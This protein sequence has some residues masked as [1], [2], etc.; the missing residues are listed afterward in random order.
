MVAVQ[1]WLWWLHKSTHVITLHSILHTCMYTRECTCDSWH[2]DGHRESHQL[3]SQVPGLD[4]T[5]QS[6]GMPTRGRL[7]EGQRKDL[8]ARFFATSCESTITSKLKVKNILHILKLLNYILK[9]LITRRTN[10]LYL[11]GDRC[12]CGDHFTVDTNVKLWC[13][14]ETNISYMSIS[15]QVLK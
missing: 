3:D 7:S 12:Y 10:F 4:S 6:R 13:T 14:P 5:L 8:A 9:V 11:Y 15:P 2:L 1:L